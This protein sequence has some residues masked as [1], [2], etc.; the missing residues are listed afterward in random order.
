VRVFVAGGTGLV[1]SAIVSALVSSRIVREVVVLSRSE[2]RVAA[3]LRN[4]GR[5]ADGV[6]PLVIDAAVFGD[7]VALRA[8]IQRMVPRLDVAIASVGAGE[9][10]GRRFADLSTSAY[11][12]MMSE[13]LGAHVAF[14]LATLPLLTDDGM[15]LGIGGGAAYAPMRGGGVISIA[16][17]AQVMMTR[18]LAAENERPGVRIREL[19]I[20]APVVPHETTKRRGTI[21]PE[22]VGG[23]VEELI[24]T[25][26]TTRPHVETKGS[27]VRMW[28]RD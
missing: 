14:A 24:G 27:I 8:A 12:D 2:T 5:R 21:S 25:G 20:D 11:N 6:T 28:A 1:G 9:P 19:I 4:L 15:Y 18:V 26:S 22:E 16:A 17:A 10:D 3:L 7:A 23:V 13:M